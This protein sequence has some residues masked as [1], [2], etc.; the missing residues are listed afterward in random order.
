MRLSGEMGKG[1]LKLV[2]TGCETNTLKVSIL[3]SD[4]ETSLTLTN[5]AKVM[6]HTI[7]DMPLFHSKNQAKN[8]WK[9]FTLI[10]NGSHST[11]VE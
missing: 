2:C 5:D 7:K 9:F 3:R 10:L 11:F 4:L 6:H 8:K 1:M